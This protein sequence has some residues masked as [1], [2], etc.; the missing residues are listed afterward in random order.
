MVRT[1]HY[2]VVRR[3]RSKALL[4]AIAVAG[5]AWLARS[6]SVRVE[7]V[8]DSMRP[9]LEPGDRLLLRRRNRRTSAFLPGDLVALADP[10]EPARIVVKRLVAVGPDGLEVH[11]DNAGASTD[12]R[13]YGPVAAEAVRGRVVYRYHPASRRGRPGR[14]VGGPGSDTSSGR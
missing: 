7:V 8:G 14:P 1:A 2:P 13:S 3:A 12:S 9:T 11:G 5:A 6:G 4:L 10:R